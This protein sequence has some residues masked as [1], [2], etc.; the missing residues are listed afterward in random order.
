MNSFLHK[1]I[2]LAAAL[3]ILVVAAGHCVLAADDILLADFEGKDYGDWKATGE[4]FGPGPARGTL[5][6]QM[7]VTGFLGKGLVNSY[8]GGDKSTGTLTSP[9]FAVERKYLNFL[10]GGGNHPGETCVNLLL[11]GKAVS[12]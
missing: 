11:D 1:T 6:N 10:I 7:P 4:A 9:P 5:P 2:Y 8:Y 3:C 12:T